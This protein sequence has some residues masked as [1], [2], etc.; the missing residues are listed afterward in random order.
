MA[1]SLTVDNLTGTGTRPVGADS[2]GVL[3]TTN[4]FQ[5]I[6]N[7]LGADVNLNNTANYFDGPSVAQGSTGTW[8]VSGL[9]SVTDVGSAEF[10]A[11]LW[12]GTTVIASGS[13][14]VGGANQRQ[15]IALSGFISSPAGN[16][17]ISV[18][19]IT[20]TTGKISFNTTGNSK[21]STITA[22]RIA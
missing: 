12:D 22:I 13:V 20:L 2:S 15:N 1:A 18:R 9:V 19:D 16:L 7:S 11:K 3:T 10:Y 17:R 6:T 8:F 5:P 14:T 21:D 4:V